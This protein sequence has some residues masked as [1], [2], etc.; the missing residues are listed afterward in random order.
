MHLYIYI[1]II[2]IFIF[3]INNLGMVLEFEDNNPY[4]TIK[5]VGQNLFEK[6]ILSIIRPG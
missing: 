4:R 2:P 5:T 6:E 3:N 1:S